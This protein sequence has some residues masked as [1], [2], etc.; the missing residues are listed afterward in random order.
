MSNL[1]IDQEPHLIG[2]FL[3]MWEEPSPEKNASKTI[4]KEI[5][6]REPGAK[7]D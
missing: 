6:T 1:I 7:V 4:I 2:G 5:V 3:K